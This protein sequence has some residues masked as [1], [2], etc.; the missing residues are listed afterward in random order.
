MQEAEDWGGK[1]R[2]G[3]NYRKTMSYL[4][5]QKADVR[6]TRVI[7]MNSN[8]PSSLRGLIIYRRFLIVTIPDEHT[9]LLFLPR[10][11]CFKPLKD[12]EGVQEH[13]M[14]AVEGGLC[15]ATHTHKTEPSVCVK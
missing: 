3:D 11:E 8:I 6:T 9:A 2:F 12:N 13:L 5:Q 14:E 10:L 7:S 15:I 1:I 4:P